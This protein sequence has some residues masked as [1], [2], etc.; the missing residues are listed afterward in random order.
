MPP[1]HQRPEW[2]SYEITPPVKACL[3]RRFLSRKLD[4]SCNFKIARVHQ[5]R[6]LVQFAAVLSQ[7]TRRLNSLCHISLCHISRSRIRWLRSHYERQSKSSCP[8]EKTWLHSR[9]YQGK[10]VNPP[11][12]FS[13]QVV[14][15]HCTQFFRG[16]YSRVAWMFSWRICLH[17]LYVHCRSFRFKVKGSR[18]RSGDVFLDILFTSKGNSALGMF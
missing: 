16:Y 8:T 5:V 2:A 9:D 11:F 7:E 3:H 13:S 14:F 15:R 18:Q 17:V 10:R 6:F 12:R 4:A 1:L